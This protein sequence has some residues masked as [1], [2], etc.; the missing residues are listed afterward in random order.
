MTIEWILDNTALE[1]RIGQHTLGPYLIKISDNEES[2]RNTASMI[3]D[4]I[5]LTYSTIETF[6]RHERMRIACGD[7]SLD[8]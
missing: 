8:D 6:A 1:I 5:S 7:N 4:L 3:N 2:L